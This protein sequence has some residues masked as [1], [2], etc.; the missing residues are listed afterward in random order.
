MHSKKNYQTFM[1]HLLKAMPAEQLTLSWIM[2]QLCPADRNNYLTT[3]MLTTLHTHYPKSCTEKD[4]FSKLKQILLT[5]IDDPQIQNELKHRITLLSILQHAN[6]ERRQ[7]EHQYYCEL[8]D[9]VAMYTFF[10]E[11]Y[12]HLLPQIKADIEA[13]EKADQRQNPWLPAKIALFATSLIS[14]NALVIALLA[15]A[16]SL[17]FLPLII[18][19][20]SA[21]LLG[22]L[23]FLV[24]LYEIH[25]WEQDY[26]DLSTLKKT[27]D[28]CEAAKRYVSKPKLHS[29]NNHITHLQALTTSFTQLLQEYAE[30][31][32]LM[33]A[34]LNGKCSTVKEIH[35]NLEE[36]L[37]IQ[38]EC[39][40][41]LQPKHPSS[42]SQNS[43]FRQPSLRRISI[44]KSESPGLSSN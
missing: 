29:I 25:Q 42:H 39:W 19:S 31:E 12:S 3:P 9:V 27:F 15:S 26:N 41:Q 10:S 36:Q 30:G 23:P 18:L 20:A 1:H 4:F 11:Q 2:S 6:S 8:E 37:K 14:S 33:E 17:A 28:D 32:C 34:A 5:H 35:K 22:T 7:L 44:E 43:M 38:T 24:T 13:L 21:M 40:L 16:A